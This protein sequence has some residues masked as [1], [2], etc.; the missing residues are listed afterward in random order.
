[1]RHISCQE[2]SPL[3]KNTKHAVHNKERED[4]LDR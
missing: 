1:M 4:E 3:L 2:M